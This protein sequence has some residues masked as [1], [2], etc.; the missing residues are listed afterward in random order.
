MESI[1]RKSAQP[2]VKSEEIFLVFDDKV[3]AEQSRT[4]IMAHRK[5]ASRIRA[6]IIKDFFRAQE[7][8]FA[9]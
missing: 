5:E 9:L 6:Q 3:K 1:R 2:L 7:R 4:Y 8:R